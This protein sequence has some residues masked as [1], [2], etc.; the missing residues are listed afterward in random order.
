MAQGCE[1]THTA[2]GL[3]HSEGRKAP[4]WPHHLLTGRVAH[5]FLWPLTRRLGKKRPSADGGATAPLVSGAPPLRPSTV[6]EA[7]ALVA[8]VQQWHPRASLSQRKRRNM[9]G[10]IPQSRSLRLLH[11]FFGGSMSVLHRIVSPLVSCTALRRVV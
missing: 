8:W 7:L 9:A 2:R 3:A 10:V 4:G 5:G 6:P 1:A 11:V